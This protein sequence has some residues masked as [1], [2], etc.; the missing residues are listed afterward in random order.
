MEKMTHAEYVELQRSRVARMASDALNGQLDILEAA[1]QIAALRSELE[2][3][4]DDPDLMAFV[5]IQSETETLPIG[6]EAS[7]WAEEALLRKAPEVAR[8]REWA[9]QTAGSELKNLVA[10]FSSP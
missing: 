1:R 5:V 8:A 7:H 3:S 2:V 6:V 4:E 10:R 9:W